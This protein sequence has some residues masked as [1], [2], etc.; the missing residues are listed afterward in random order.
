VGEFDYLKHVLN[1]AGR[2][3]QVGVELVEGTDHSFA[4]RMGRVGVQQYIEKWLGNYLPLRE[5]VPVNVL[6]P[7]ADADQSYNR[8]HVD[9]LQP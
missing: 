5:D 1:L 9:C 7:E 8:D 2:K 4:N 3:S 6:L